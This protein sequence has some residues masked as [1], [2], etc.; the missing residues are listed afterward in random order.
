MK[1]PV[2]IDAQKRGKARWFVFGASGHGKVVIDTIERTN[3]T[4]AFIVDDDPD[5]I[6]QSFFGYEVVGRDEL[7]IRRA[8]IDY[9]VVAVGNNAIRGGVVNWLKAQHLAFEVLVHP[10]AMIARGVSIGEGTVIFAAAVVNSDACIG[11]HN[12]INTASSIDH[13]CILGDGIHIAPGVRLCGG[14]SVGDHA[15]L[16]VGSVVLPGV[17]IGAGATVAAGAVVNRNVAPYARV[18]G[19]PAQT[20]E[21]TL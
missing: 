6:G 12:I 13:D 16:G 21:K 3:A 14:V 17:N 20:L 11:S 4:V 2:M 5:K 15:L 1:D 8:D 19:I 7:L 18:G 9:G 10:G